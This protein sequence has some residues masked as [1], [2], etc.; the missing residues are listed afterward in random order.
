MGSFDEA[1][2][3]LRYLWAVAPDG[4]TAK[5]WVTEDGTR[6]AQAAKA[7]AE[8]HWSKYD[9][10]VHARPAVTCVRPSVARASA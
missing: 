3:E 2:E 1:V 4:S 5:R 9:Q 10:R 8:A 6:A 7:D